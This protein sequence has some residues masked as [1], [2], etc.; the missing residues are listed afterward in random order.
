MLRRPVEIAA[1][2]GHSL[3]YQNAAVRPVEADIHARCNILVGRI[4]ALMK[5]F[6]CGP[7]REFSAR[8]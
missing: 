5:V 4:A 6:R 8:D 2:S 1:H 3:I 7:L